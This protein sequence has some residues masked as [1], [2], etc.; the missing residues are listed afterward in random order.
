VVVVGVRDTSVRF[1]L[2]LFGCGWG[3][4]RFFLV[5]RGGGTDSNCRS[6]WG[7]RAFPYFLGD[8]GLDPFCRSGGG[9]DPLC[10]TGRGYRPPPY[11]GGGIRTRPLGREGRRVPPLYGSGF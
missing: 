9:T 2:F 5:G 3:G 1:F 6:V 10:R 7:A 8:W 11:V 4:V